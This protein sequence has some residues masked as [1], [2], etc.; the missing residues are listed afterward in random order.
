MDAF[1]SFAVLET[2]KDKII[3]DD[4]RFHLLFVSSDSVSAVSLLIICMETFFS[5]GW[6]KKSAVLM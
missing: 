6:L 3:L 1:L 4:E 5:Y 2:L